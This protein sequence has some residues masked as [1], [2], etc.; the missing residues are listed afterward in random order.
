MLLIIQASSIPFKHGILISDIITSG[1]FFRIIPKPTNPLSAVCTRYPISEKYDARDSQVD[2][3]LSI[4][5]MLFNYFG[6]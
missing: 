6:F 2:A 5:N 1:L 4:I 3:S